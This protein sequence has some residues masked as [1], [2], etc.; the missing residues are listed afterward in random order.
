MATDTSAQ[1]F[2]L[3]KKSGIYEASEIEALTQANES[4]TD[5]RVLARNLVSQGKLAPQLSCVSLFAP[6]KTYNVP[7]IS[8]AVAVIA[9]PQLRQRFLDARRGLVGTPGPLG[10]VAAEA[11][12]RD[13][14]GWLEELQTY[15][16]TNR[17]LLAAV[18]GAR[19]TTVEA[20]YLAWIDVQDI[21]SGAHGCRCPI[22]PI[23]VENDVNVVGAEGVRKGT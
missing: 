6:T 22:A 12:W 8:C 7:G 11:A 21:A 3:L 13:S 18:T 16:R 9:D 2:A 15:L 10:Y 4:V 20:T 14:S 5:V 19:M 1:F 17:D 23:S